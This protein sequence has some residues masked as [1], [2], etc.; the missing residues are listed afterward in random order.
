MWRWAGE[1]SL[2]GG[3]VHGGHRGGGGVSEFLR[4]VANVIGRRDQRGS[5]RVAKVMIWRAL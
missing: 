3:D 1:A 4:Q 2:T 5:M